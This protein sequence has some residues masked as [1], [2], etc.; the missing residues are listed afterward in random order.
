M[1]LSLNAYA[2]ATPAAGDVTVTLPGTP[3]AGDCYVIIALVKQGTSGALEFAS[4]SGTG[5]TTHGVIDQPGRGAFLA[6]RSWQ[7]GDASTQTLH[8][9][10]VSIKFLYVAAWLI[11]PG[12]GNTVSFVSWGGAGG[13]TSGSTD[14]VTLDAAPASGDAVVVGHANDSKQTAYSNWLN[15]AFSL[16]ENE[17]QWAGSGSPSAWASAGFASGITT[18]TST[19]VS[20][21]HDDTGAAWSMIAGAFHEEAGSPTFTG[22]AA[23]VQGGD[24]SAASGT[25]TPPTFTG[26]AAVTQGADTST[27]SGTFTG[28]AFDPANLAAVQTGANVDLTWDASF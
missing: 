13:A 23:V 22:S 9:T 5:W 10:G 7:S 19:T 4:G 14:S 28:T 24:T 8:S 20:G 11:R 6:S 3:Q 26:T 21:D 17:E 18:S 16:T 15:G 1:A 2:G 27:A 12:A 25:H